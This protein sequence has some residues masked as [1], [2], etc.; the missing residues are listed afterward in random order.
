MMLPG[1]VA[2]WVWRDRPRPLGAA[3]DMLWV[4]AANGGRNT[5]PDGFDFLANY[6]AWQAASSVP[7]VPWTWIYPTTSPLAGAA[8]L[9]KVDAPAYILDVEELVPAD[10]IRRFVAELRR[11]R[12]GRPVGFSSYP[13]RA[14]FVNVNGASAGGTWD[15]LVSSCDFGCPQVYFSSQA[16]RMPQVVADMAGKP[17]HV[18]VSP[19]D[20]SGWLDV[21]RLAVGVHLG[22]S[23][24][25]S[26][27]AGWD[28]WAR[29][30]AGLQQIEEDGF[31]AALTEAEQREILAA[32]RQV[33]SGIGA[34]QGSFSSTVKATLAT[35]QALVNESRSQ[36]G[37]LAG[38]IDSLRSAVLGAVAALPTSS[39]SDADRDELAV[40]IAE[41]VSA[42]GVEIS[43]S[44]VLDALATRLAA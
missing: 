35:V 17:V 20:Y 32:A 27:V 9:A 42:A 5:G 44:A 18:A 25:A 7:L 8:A 38:K 19:A 24:W 43:P 29:A 41:R 28:G 22:V 36:T 6:R 33:N 11:L 40:A 4:R 14:Q 12:P 23:V 21:A 30:L 39:L 10:T 15:A 3:F 34:G 26:H 16:G 31:M 37:A 2:A 1:K 13:T